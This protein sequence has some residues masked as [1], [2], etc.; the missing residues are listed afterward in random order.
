[1][2]KTLLLLAA[3]ILA[4]STITPAFADGGPFNPPGK[5]AVSLR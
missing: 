5:T 3:A 1:V 2:K 4:L